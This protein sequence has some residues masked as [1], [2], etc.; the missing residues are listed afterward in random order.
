MTRSVVK[1]REL[2]ESDFEP[3]LSMMQDPIGNEMSMV[4]PPSRSE[5]R[6]QWD[7]IM[8]DPACVHRTIELDGVVV[9]RVNSYLLEDEIHVGYLIDRA[10]WGRGIMGES[11]RQFLALDGRRPLIA[12]VA[13]SNVGSCRVLEKNGF[14]LIDEYDAPETDRYRAC[15]EVKY[16]LR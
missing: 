9:G 7:R 15:V 4:Y 10:Y 6:S 1:L 16:A 5:L 3:I 8:E 11:L 12:R 14:V 13:K 2:I